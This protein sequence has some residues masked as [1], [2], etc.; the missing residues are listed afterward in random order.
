MD[1]LGAEVAQ[2]A[3]VQLVVL[4]GYDSSH[5]TKEAGSVRE[6]PDDG[7]APL[8]PLVQPLERVRALQLAPMLEREGTVRQR[9]QHGQDVL[10]L[11]RRQGAGRCGSP[12]RLPR[13]PRGAGPVVAGARDAESSTDRDRAYLWRDRLD[14]PH[15]LSPSSSWLFS[16]VPAR[17]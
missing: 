2:S 8:D 7:R 15:Q 17:T 4:L 13:R 6:D 10:A 11:L 14:R 1:R 3:T 5:E 12:L 16:G 9:V